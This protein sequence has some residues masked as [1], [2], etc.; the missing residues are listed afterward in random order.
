[1]DIFLLGLLLT[2]CSQLKIFGFSANFS[3]TS[4]LP[5]QGPQQHHDVPAVTSPHHEKKSFN[6]PNSLAA[7]R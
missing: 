4:K 2:L 5:S 7:S 6:P 1:L 3:I